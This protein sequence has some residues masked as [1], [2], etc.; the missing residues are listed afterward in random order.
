MTITYIKAVAATLPNNSDTITVTGEYVDFS[1][2]DDYLVALDNGLYVLP[3]L[4]G[5]APDVNGDSTLTLANSWQGATLNNKGLFIF[6]TFAKIYES[7]TA[8]T[9]LNDVT[10]G[11]LTKLKELLT[12]TNPTLDIS[13]GQTSSIETVPYGYLA[14]QVT[15]LISQLNSL[16]GSVQAMTKAEFFAIAEQRK[17][18]GAGSGFS[19]W[20][21]HITPYTNSNN[22]N[23]G[24]YSITSEPNRLRLG[25]VG[26]STTG[27]SRTETPIT[28]VNGA[29]M[30]LY[31]TNYVSSDYPNNIQL[32]PAPD[33]LDKSDGTGRFADLAA[34]IVAGGTSLT[35]SVI[36]R[37]DFVLLESWHEKISDKDVV[38]PLG[39]VQ[40]GSTT[41][42]AIAL[43]NTVVA[44][45]YSAFGEWD[46]VTKGYGV[47][48][49][50]L[51][52]A[53]KAKFIQDPENNIYVDDGEL[54]QVR[55]R[56]RVVKG[57]GDDWEALAFTS[58][59]IQ[60]SSGNRV[61]AQGSSTTAVDLTAATIHSFG[62]TGSST[63]LGQES[64]GTYH[65][66]TAFA[67]AH[68]GLCFA[69]PIALVQR[70]NQ[71]AFHPS[72]NNYGCAYIGRVGNL[73]VA[74]FWHSAN[75]TKPVSTVECFSEKTTNEV[76]LGS[77]TG[78]SGRPDSKFYDAINAS[79]IQ[80]LRMSSKRLPL[81]EI[82]EKYK[83]M[84]IA[85]EVRGFEGVPFT[86]VST[87]VNG[88]TDVS[89][90]KFLVVDA[91]VY[92]VGDIVHLEEPSGDYVERIVALVDLGSDEIAVSVTFSRVI[93]GYIVHQTTQTHKQANPTWTDIIGDPANIA[94]TFPDGVEAQWIPVIPDGVAAYAYPF[95][96]KFITNQLRL[97]TSNNGTTWSSSGYTP[98]TTTNTY[99]PSIIPAGN[100]ELYSYETQSHFTEDAVDI[101]RLTD[102]SPVYATNHHSEA[103][104]TSSLVGEVATGTDPSETLA[105]TKIVSDV[106]SHVSEGLITTVKYSTA[107]G[108]KDGIAYLLFNFDDAGVIDGSN[109][110]AVAIPY[111]IKG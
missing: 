10:R 111:F 1:K 31:G 91:S 82:R 95:N 87:N 70:R 77:I 36:S 89:A 59:I 2:A 75:A 56:V 30:N 47:V 33:G 38:Y 62:G 21:K 35:A 15:A 9:A 27:G 7:V 13:V 79:D 50:T 81:A 102:W 20:G 71:G 86:K 24:M 72:F 16:V 39:N 49:S 53:D 23:T 64:L 84:A 44:Q 17:R 54:I 57:L 60:Y 19:E 41:W 65:T 103:I 22:I 109:I 12:D 96:R 45:G 69:V 25:K 104:L 93:G 6:P 58:S 48:W 29:Q 40:Y 66:Q 92:T 80:D 98:N 18:D 51:S 32:P 107:I 61:A 28:L 76:Y 63:I 26:A 97:K 3:V 42:E 101:T 73:S 106:I 94:A 68:N 14:A 110:K 67:S 52:D 8:F 34:A 5:T 88:G 105:I 78:N 100:V 46:T 99:Q 85:G 90:S 4:S 74:D 108:V 37:K 55:Y 43:A 83:R 11:I